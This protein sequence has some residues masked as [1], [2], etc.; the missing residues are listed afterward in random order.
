MKSASPP[1]LASWL[2]HHQVGG[3]R[4]ESLV[5]DLTEE[6]ADGRGDRW[7]WGQVLFAVARS[8]RRALRLHGVRVL[9]AVALGWCALLMGVVLLEQ[10]SAIVRHQL[11]AFDADWPTQ[12]LQ[13]LNAY[14]SLALKIL[15]GCVDFVAGRLVVRLYRQH[16][17]FIAAVFALSIL[18]YMLPS[19]Y[20]LMQQ[21]LHNS[22]RIAALAQELAATI[23]WTASAWFGALWQIRIDNKATKLGL[24]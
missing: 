20:D 17:R 13:T 24:S 16:P 12:R 4:A 11:S 6:Y 5:G 1:K 19:I 18:A 7:Y 2:L 14:Y 22:Q 23:F 9:I 15:A 3:Y 10:M 21:A 8:Y